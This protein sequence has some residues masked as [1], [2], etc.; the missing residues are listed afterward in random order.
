MPVWDLWPTD[1]GRILTNTGEEID[2]LQ[3]QVEAYSENITSAA[4][5]A[6]TLGTAA[7]SQGSDQA[8]S[9]GGNQ[10]TD[11]G[12]GGAVAGAVGEFATRTQE[13]LLY[14][15]VRGARSVKGASDAAVQ[16]LRGDQD[17]AADTMHKTLAEPDMDAWM[18]KA[19]AEAKGEG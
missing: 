5:S 6:G 14:I 13:D 15:G 7:G 8:A 2:G 1:I 16:Y 11:G 12:V 18:K 9:Q 10:R 17:M 3:A 4:R 19:R